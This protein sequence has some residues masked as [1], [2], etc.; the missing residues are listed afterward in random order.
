MHTIKL[1]LTYYLNISVQAAN[2][3]DCQIESKKI[4]SVARIQSN[5][6]ETFLPELE[7]STRKPT[8]GIVWIELTSRPSYTVNDALIGHARQRRDL[9]GCSE[10]STVDA[11][12]VN[13]CL[14]LQFTS[15]QFSSVRVCIAFTADT[16]PRGN[17]YTS[18]RAS[19]LIEQTWP[20]VRLRP[21]C[22]ISGTVRGL[23]GET[24]QL[25]DQWYS[26]GCAN[27]HPI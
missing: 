20:N 19:Q 27:V 17:S 21:A 11:Q 10:T 4:D 3:S 1:L 12:S 2:L 23:V 5:R 18:P 26:P 25:I 24:P 9:I 14:E 13:T 22:V 7:C 6:I 8:Y 16:M 15:V